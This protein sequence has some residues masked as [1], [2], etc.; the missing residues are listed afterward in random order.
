ME[1]GY[2]RE[3]YKR[4]QEEILP[5]KERRDEIWDKIEK[6][7]AN[8]KRRKAA[9]R[10]KA[11]VGVAAAA[12]ALAF[13]LPQTNLADSIYGFWMNYFGGN[14]D[15]GHEAFH[16]IYEDQD[17]HVRMKIDEMVSDGASVYMDI[18]YEALDEIGKAWLNEQEFDSYS[19][20]FTDLEKTDLAKVGSWNV[21]EVRRT[22]KENARYFSCAFLSSGQYSPK[23]WTETLFY[24][25]YHHQ[26]IGQVELKSCLET[27]AYRLEPEGAL[28]DGTSGNGRADSTKGNAGLKSSGADGTGLSPS[29]Y[30]TPTYL[31]VSKLSAAIFGLNQGA[32]Y[33][34]K[35]EN[36]QEVIGY[37]DGFLKEILAENEKEDGGVMDNIFLIRDDGGKTVVGG[38]EIGGYG[39]VDDVPGCDFLIA[40]GAFAKKE[41]GEFWNTPIEHPESLA[42][43]EIGGVR[44]RLAKDGEWK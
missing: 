34:I 14:V 15:I 33:Q 21:D 40:Y 43:I 10:V 22:E 17:E 29:E 28:P 38:R 41:D 5:G 26:G 13:F 19:I 11:A 27:Y 39:L 1:N 37:T 36:G 20:R 35:K 24:P 4:M 3:D 9:G 32:F 6:E 23:E 42:G 12:I 16:D 31:I 8:R 18:S 30:Y 25:M 7:A 2:W 44:Y